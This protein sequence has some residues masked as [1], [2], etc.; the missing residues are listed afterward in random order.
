MVVLAL[1]CQTPWSNEQVNNVTS[2][3]PIEAYGRITDPQCVN[4]K[5]SQIT[6]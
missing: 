4:G 3:K 1:V 5:S 6:H 2:Y